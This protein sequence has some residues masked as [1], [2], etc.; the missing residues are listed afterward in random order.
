[1]NTDQSL[2][3]QMGFGTNVRHGAEGIDALLCALETGYRHIDTA[4]SYKT[5]REVGEAVRRSG[6]PRGEVFITTKVANTNLGPGEVI[7]SIERSLEL[8]TLDQADLVLIHWPARYGSIAPD[9]Y[10]PQLAEAQDRGLTRL[11]GVSNFTIALLEES[12][13]IL[14]EGRIVN[15]QIELNP[16][17]QNRKIA[18][19]CANAG[20]SVTCFRPMA[21]GRLGD[22]PVL[23]EIAATHDATIEQVAL[24]FEMAKGYC[25][26]PTS[27]RPEHIHS[28]FAALDLTLS[29]EEIAA[30]ERI[31]RGQRASNPEWGPDWD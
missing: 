8:L 23:A 11:I 27:G 20:I 3:P 13:R 2:I 30:I 28:N 14:G 22:E 10:L 31:D 15:N 29:A 24:A 12:R 16:L 21:R 26:I 6:L 7:P 17:M 4:Q 5:E 18:D 25:V 19:Y 9:V 1:M